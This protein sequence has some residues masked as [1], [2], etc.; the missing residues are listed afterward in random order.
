MH[1]LPSCFKGHKSSVQPLWTKKDSNPYQ[2]VKEWCVNGIHTKTSGRPGTLN[3]FIKASKTSQ[4]ERVV[5]Q[6][7]P[8]CLQHEPAQLD[9]NKNVK[10]TL[11][12]RPKPGNMSRRNRLVRAV[13]QV[14][15]SPKLKE[16]SHRKRIGLLFQH[17]FCDHG[18]L[19]LWYP[20]YLHGWMSPII[21]IRYQQVTF[22][23]W[24]IKK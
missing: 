8:I 5:C 23:Y 1:Q 18:N 24:G 21:K 6:S 11:S 10:L 3:G 16:L 2:F 14:W 15:A 20:K 9:C 22:I 13:I 7:G 4:C 12:S 17:M 19:F